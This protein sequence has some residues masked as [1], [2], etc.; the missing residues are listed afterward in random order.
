MCGI[1]GYLGKQ[2]A[3]GILLDCLGRL[4]YR[5]YDSAGIATI[6]A[7]KLGMLRCAGKNADLQSL[8]DR[9]PLPGGI[10][11]AHTRW[12]THGKPT[13][14]NSHPHTDCNSALAIVHNGII[15][16]YDEL[17]EQ[18]E[19]D[20]HRFVSQTDSE[21]IAHLIEAN[22]AANIEGGLKTAVRKALSLI[23]GTYALAVI[24]QQESDR[25]VVARS[26]GPPLVIGHAEDGLYVSSDIAAILH[27]TQDI[28]ILEDNEIAEICRDG[29]VITML[30]GT[31][32]ERPRIQIA[33]KQNAAERNGFPHFMLK[34]IHEQPQA[35][36]DTIQG[37]TLLA[38]GAVSFP[39]AAYTT[40]NEFRLT[41]RIT[42]LACGSS[43]HAGLVGKHLIESI[44]GTPVD[45]DIAS[46]YRY[47]PQFSHAGTL[48]IGISQSGETADTLGALK[49]A[50]NSGAGILAI[51]NVNGSSMGREA[52]GVIYTHA[53][54]EIGV[55]STKTFTCQLTALV[56]FAI[57]LGLANGNLSA[58]AAEALLQELLHLPLL[59]ERILAQSEALAE[60]AGLFDDATN[61][62]YLG[63]GVLFPLAIEGALKLKE[64]S[65]IHA[66]AYPAGEL[67]HGP[68]ALIDRNI[69]IVVIATQG[70][71]YEKL[72]TAIQEVKARDGTVIVMATEG[73]RKIGAIVEHVFYVP[74]TTE[75]LM[76]I[77]MAVPMQL[78]AY[79]IAARRGCEI[80]Q[81][82]NLAKSVTVD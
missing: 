75:L 2:Q 82:R 12:A 65:Y 26:G 58:R 20:G 50:R 11:I 39:Q 37:Q 52:D 30:D 63:R 13:D 23:Q 62:L 49:T 48:A 56:L 17:K 41:Q 5:G 72:L 76:P 7:G 15:E 69:P 81:P 61:S 78:L 79:H 1:V 59:I 36:L 10:G 42:I 8:L 19:N 32:I 74:A 57:S 46:E 47:R 24:S 3:Q 6:D 43:W 53:G 67:K 35:V 77:L 4:E 45:V 64:I 44:S 22:L 73:D 80:D 54:P 16:N 51:C 25:I 9:S 29:A 21:V 68:I 66:E 70:P 31:P 33:W 27:Y 55:A 28:Q 71:L 18:M 40:T 34:E 14:S 38:G 60:L